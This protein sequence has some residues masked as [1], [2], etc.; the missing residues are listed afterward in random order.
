MVAGSNINPII[1]GILSL[2]GL[3]VGFFVAEKDSKTFLM[4]STAVV[5]VSFAGLQG[6]VLSAAILGF[7][8]V[9][10]FLT[11]VLGGLM[12]LF[13]PATIVVAVKTVFSIA[14]S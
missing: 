6:G 11:N 1:L 12:F 14:K 13:I 7:V 8:N 3:I 5:L 2:L 4:V 10:K 9:S